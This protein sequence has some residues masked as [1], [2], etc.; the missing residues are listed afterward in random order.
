MK[1]LHWGEHL[2]PAIFPARH[3]DEAGARVRRARFGGDAAPTIARADRVPIALPA[4]G[5]SADGGK[6]RGWVLTLGRRA[7]AAAQQRRMR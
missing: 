7:I 1:S 4:A 5:L 2:R 6:D 3:P